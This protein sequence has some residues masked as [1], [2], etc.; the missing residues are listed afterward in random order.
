MMA[1]PPQFRPLTNTELG[2]LKN[3]DDDIFWPQPNQSTGS[4]PWHN[5]NEIAMN[6]GQASHY[7]AGT[8]PVT[9]EGLKR[10][11][12]KN[13]G[14]FK[15]PVPILLEDERRGDRFMKGLLP[16][17]RTDRRLQHWKSLNYIRHENGDLGAIVEIHDGDFHP[18][19]IDNCE[20]FALSI[21]LDR[22]TCWDN[23]KPKLKAWIVSIKTHHFRILEA[24]LDQQLNKNDFHFSIVEERPYTKGRVKSL[25]GGDEEWKWL[26]S[27]VFA[28]PT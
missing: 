5:I 24:Y 2:M 11:S 4:Q 10:Y 22:Q 8:V 28:Q 12:F 20:L 26:L 25:D 27:W 6:L 9:D 21:L 17:S 19:T 18:N 23:N 7:L 13:V 3:R 1:I 16:M 15:V 14:P